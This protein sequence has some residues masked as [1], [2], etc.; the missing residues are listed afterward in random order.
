MSANDEL[1]TN[2]TL[3]I[4]P[5][6][7]YTNDLV[8]EGKKYKTVADLAR[9]V[10]HKDVFIDTLTGEK[11][12]LLE[13]LS[14]RMTMEEAIEKMQKTQTPNS[15]LNSGSL[16]PES[17]SNTRSENNTAL[18]D[19]TIQKA[20]SERVRDELARASS[21][22]A[23]KANVDLVVKT[24]TEAWGDSFSAKLEAT[25]NELSVSKEWITEQARVAPQALLK[26]IG[27][28]VSDK[29][30]AVSSSLFSPAASGMNAA[31][32]AANRGG[33]LPQEEKYSYWK[34]LR[35][36]DPDLYHSPA[37]ALKRHNAAIKHGEAFYQH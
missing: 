31:A 13:D 23:A 33:N 26:L 28:T 29:K 18:N 2:K 16:P 6:K 7:D 21:E 20:I 10:L 32:L 25:A 30:E 22:A 11:K 19:E 15:Q 17:G 14:K 4:D 34:S 35:Q 3:T 24:L 8:G 36:S 12:E 37:M 27:A 5:E 1:F 9:A